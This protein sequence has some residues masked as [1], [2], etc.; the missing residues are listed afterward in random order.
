M[1]KLK[2]ILLLIVMPILISA[3]SSSFLDTD[4]NE[5]ASDDQVQ[6]AINRDPSK[7]KGYISGFYKNLFAPESQRSHDDFGLK[8]IELATDMMG[9]DIAYLTSHFFVY[10]YLLDNRGSSYRRPASTWQEFYAVINGTNEVISK[11]IEQIDSGD[12]TVEKMLGE[13]FVIRAYSYFWLINMYQ[14][15]YQWNKDKPGIPIYNE[16][17][18]LLNRVPVKEVYNQILSD[19]DKGYNLLKGKK[20][21][22]KGEISEYAAAAIY[23]KVLQFVDDYPNQWETVAKYAQEAIKGGS[24]MTEAELLSGFNTVDLSEVLWGALIDGESNT[25]Y[26]SFMSHMDPY[27]PGYGGDLGNYKMIASDLYDKIPETDIRKKWFG[28]KIESEDNPHYHVQQYIQKKFVDVGSLGKGGTFTSD[29]IYLRTAEMYFVAAEA[30]A[31][32]G[33]NAEAQKLLEEV[34]KSRNP[35]YSASGKDL[36]EEIRI[37]K[38]IEMWGEGVR[39][40]DM[41][42]RGEPLNR[43]GS[44]NHSST[45]VHELPA[46]DKKFI[47]KIPDDE[48][49]AN[50]EIGEQND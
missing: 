49:N 20:A 19:L 12:E 29:Y 33:K 15:P 31:N 13:S 4:L 50:K 28:I 27:S 42:R 38:R 3:C 17:D 32:L 35:D 14:H 37:Q 44:V 18:I 8:G 41:K 46:N 26:A 30:F 23:A 7:I 43:K 2:Y 34:V 21:A 39:L 40:F 5:N 48:M 25:F 36:L 22:S 6:D 47:Y 45:T 9:E 11:L 16:T 10:D 24:L 1:K